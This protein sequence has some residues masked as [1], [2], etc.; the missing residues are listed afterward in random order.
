M[1][2]TCGNGICNRIGL[3]VVLSKTLWLAILVCVISCASPA[4][5]YLFASLFLLVFDCLYSSLA[6]LSCWSN[7]LE[8]N[9]F[10]FIFRLAKTMYW[11]VIIVTMVCFI[12]LLG[13]SQTLLLKDLSLSVSIICT[14]C[15]FSFK[16]TCALCLCIYFNGYMF[17]LQANESIGIVN[18]YDLILENPDQRC[19]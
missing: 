11:M 1:D 4:I 12:F 18:T 7:I 3:F 16:F 6:S 19:I 2:C 5:L 13:C 9:P 14:D 8:D 17:F 15:H 10:L